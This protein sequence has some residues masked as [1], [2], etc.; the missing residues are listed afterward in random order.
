MKKILILP[1]FI[2]S[3]AAINKPV[4]AIYEINNLDVPVM[5]EAVKAALARNN[6]GIDKNHLEL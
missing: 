2:C 5:L 4:M 6:S 3:L 1:L